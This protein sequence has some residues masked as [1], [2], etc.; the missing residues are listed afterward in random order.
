[1]DKSLA[2]H[3]HRLAADRGHPGV[4]ENYAVLLQNGQGIPM[5]KS[6]TTPHYKLQPIKEMR[7]FS[8]IMVSSSRKEM[9]F[10]E[11]NHLQRIISNWLLIKAM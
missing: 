9:I 4:Q 2:A 5:T 1:M 10:R 8:S 3:Y 7:P 6:L 11:T